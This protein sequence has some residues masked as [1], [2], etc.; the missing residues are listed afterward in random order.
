MF[1]VIPEEDAQVL[2]P[3]HEDLPEG[4]LVIPNFISEKEEMEFTKKLFVEESSGKFVIFILV[5]E[6]MQE[7]LRTNL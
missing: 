2:S 5:V 4:L 3:F 1:S 6:F 7:G